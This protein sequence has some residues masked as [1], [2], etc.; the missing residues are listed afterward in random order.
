[1]LRDV[2]ALAA[3][4][5]LVVSFLYIVSLGVDVATTNQHAT[6]R[7]VPSRFSSFHRVLHVAAVKR[8]LLFRG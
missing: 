3:D 8:V 6:V 5:A 7:G 4:I 1:M 2:D